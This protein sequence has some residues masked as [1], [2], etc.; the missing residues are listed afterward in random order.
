MGGATPHAASGSLPHILN[1]ARCDQ[2]LFRPWEQRQ[3]RLLVIDAEH[4][5]GAPAV[6]RRHG[7]PRAR[8]RQRRG[9]GGEGEGGAATCDGDG[10]IDPI[11]VGELQL[12]PRAPSELSV[13][14]VS[15]GFGYTY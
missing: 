8:A 10:G 13:A 5:H 2:D 1:Q 6:P 7:W 3:P 9:G 4:R 12:G 14:M 11:A 15:T